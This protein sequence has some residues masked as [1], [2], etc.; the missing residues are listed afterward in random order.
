[1]VD[2]WNW[3]GFEGVPLEVEV[4]CAHEEVDLLVNGESQGRKKTNRDSQWIA[5]W[6]VPYEAGVLEAVAYNDS[7]EVERWKLVTA[8]KPR[9]IRLAADRNEL[10]ADGQ[11]LS[12]I[13]VELTDQA[14]NRNRTANQLVEFEIEGPG[15][16]LG[17]GS[18][19]PMSTESYRQP[20]R[21]AYQGRCLVIIRTTSAPGEIQLRASS[22]NLESAEITLV[23]KL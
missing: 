9:N 16:I 19:N 8:D 4:Y 5:R 13:T 20:K 11:D 10:S 18:S 15:E 7:Q 1:V 3:E 22:Q 21:K 2:R 12:Y 17:V 6:N 14:G 23:S